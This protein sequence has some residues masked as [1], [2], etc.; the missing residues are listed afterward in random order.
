MS[1]TLKD[2][3]A[4]VGVSI[5]TVSRAISGDPVKKVRQS[6]QEK[7]AQSMLRLGYRLDEEAAAFLHAALPPTPSNMSTVPSIG[8]I[9]ASPTKS[10]AEPFF[11]ELLAVLSSE[12]ARNDC[13]VEY[14]LT[15]SA[16]GRKKLQEVALSR[17]VSGVI[18]LGRFEQDLLQHIKAAVPHCVHTGVNYLEYDTDEVI[19]DG[20]KAIATLYDHFAVLGY[21]SIGYIGPVV[22]E[23]EGRNQHHRF[24]SYLQCLAN[25]GS[26][27]QD[28]WA[29]NAED[30]TQEGYSAMCQMIDDNALPRAIICASDVVAC[31]VLRAA[32][33][34]GIAIPQDVAIASIDNISLS[35]FLTPSLTTVDISK[36]D[37]ARLSVSM[38]KDKIENRRTKNIRLDVPHELMIRESCGYYKKEQ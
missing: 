8:I 19:C 21:P 23:L 3:A 18:L 13:T 16:M 33:E 29:F 38:L 34:K 31:G 20:A 15:E 26:V 36:E 2:I 35:Q 17:P 25:H 7:I 27:R 5:S 28:K 30:T 14:V 6:T 32:Q 9:L 1:V 37:L 10:F 4:D 24:S 12:I 22:S 11:A